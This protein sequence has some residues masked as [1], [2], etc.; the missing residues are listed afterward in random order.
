MIYAR[1][2]GFCFIAHSCFGITME[3]GLQE[4]VLSKA[5]VGNLGGVRLTWALDKGG[6]WDRLDILIAGTDGER[7]GSGACFG[8]VR[9]SL[10]GLL[11]IDINRGHRLVCD[12]EGAM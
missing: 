1:L 2:A 5:R 6:S 7:A 3:L 8:F 4:S 11:R 10:L 12:R 9:I